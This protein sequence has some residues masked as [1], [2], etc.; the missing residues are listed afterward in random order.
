MGSIADNYDISRG[1]IVPAGC[2]AITEFYGSNWSKFSHAETLNGTKVA[3]E[4]YKCKR[5]HAN[6]EQLKP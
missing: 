6:I 5:L 2:F 1:L 3:G 4:S